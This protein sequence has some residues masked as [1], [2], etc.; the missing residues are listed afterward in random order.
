MDPLH[1][2]ILLKDDDE[3]EY[4]IFKFGGLTF[5]FYHPL[6]T[7]PVEYGERY[8]F[9]VTDNQN[10]LNYMKRLVEKFEKKLEKKYLTN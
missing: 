3:K 2:G 6:K 10:Y 4:V 9:F 7:V 5:L 1:Y 8:C